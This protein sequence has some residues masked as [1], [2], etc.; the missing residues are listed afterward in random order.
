MSNGKYISFLIVPEEGGKTVNFRIHRFTLRIGLVVVGL[1]FIALIVAAIFYGRLVKQ[2]SDV[3]RLRSENAMLLEQNAE[4]IKFKKELQK[5]RKFVNRIAELA[6]LEGITEEDSLYS[7][8]SAESESISEQTDGVSVP[9]GYPIRGFISKRFSESGL[10]GEKHLG[11][12]FS[13]PEGS[14]IRSTADGIVK[15]ANWDDYFGYT[16]VIEHPGGYSTTYAHNKELRVSEGD[17]V[18]RGDVIALSG[19]SGKSS[20]PHL[21]YEIRKDGKQL[22]PED[23]L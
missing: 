12:D 9:S 10:F 21:H 16:L 11:L 1:L 23:F 8:M 15:S 5:N 14:M 17:K 2:A 20:G 4:V 3:V 7:E 19:N 13:C 18:K 6:G 22:D